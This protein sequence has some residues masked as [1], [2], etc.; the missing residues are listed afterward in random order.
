MK[1]IEKATMP[2][3]TEIQ[4]EDWSEK[5]TEKYPNLYGLVIGAYPIAKNT[6]R[7]GWVKSGESFRLG[8]GMNSYAGYTNEQVKE[9][10]EALKNGIK[11]LQ[12][13]AEHFD[14]G[15]KDKYYLGMIDTYTE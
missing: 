11:T 2:N 9:D 10:Y 13:L 5:N 3:G 4:L 8:I 15:N 6:S 14:N 7:H 1:I 12:D